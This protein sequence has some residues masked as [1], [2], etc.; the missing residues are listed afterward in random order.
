MASIYSAHMKPFLVSFLLTIISRE[1]YL[2][3][4]HSPFFV[5]HAEAYNSFLPFYMEKLEKQVETD[6]C[7]L[8]V[9][10]FY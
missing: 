10:M 8:R 1:Y 3:G 9:N 6:L 5:F 2:F 4:L 7:V